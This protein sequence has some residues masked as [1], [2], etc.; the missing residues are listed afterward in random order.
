[1]S[2]KELNQ[3]DNIKL[4]LIDTFEPNFTFSNKSI[5]RFKTHNSDDAKNILDKAEKLSGLKKK[6]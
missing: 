2:K 3:N 1:M 6:N 4:D 5:N